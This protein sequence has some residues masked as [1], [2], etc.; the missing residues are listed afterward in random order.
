MEIVSL[1]ASL[2][3]RDSTALA[4]HRM[5]PVSN[6]HNLRGSPA[7]TRRPSADNTGGLNRTVPNPEGGGRS[8]LGGCEKMCRPIFASYT[9]MHVGR[10]ILE[11]ATRPV[12]DS[13]DIP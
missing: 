10:L 7:K 13:V 12:V 5:R 6:S 2:P 4:C 8:S 1:L 3:A 11:I 9:S